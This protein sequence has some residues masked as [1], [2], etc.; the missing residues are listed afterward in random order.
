MPNQQYTIRELAERANTTIRTIRYYTE[1]GLLPPPVI[2]GK[3]AYYT[4]DHLNRLELVRRMKDAYLPLREIR[5]VML[6]ISE[7]EVIERL[8]DQIQPNKRSVKE[9]NMDDSALS[10]SSEAL[11]YISRLMSE[12][13]VFRPLARN[14]PNQN[15]PSKH[16]EPLPAA[17]N[18]RVSGNSESVIGNWQR[19]QLASGVE[20][21]LRTPA[22]PDLTDRVEQLISFAM[23]LFRRPA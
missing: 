21:H 20:L 9:S 5:Q 22:D 6:S 18:L 2:Q 12:Q 10:K 16:T 7:T 1:E 19:I 4:R 23:K 14:Q 17:S 11:E 3:N 13:A 15:Q 8:S